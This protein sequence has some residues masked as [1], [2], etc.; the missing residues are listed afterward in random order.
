MA[1][2]DIAPD[3]TTTLIGSDKVE[4]TSV[5]DPSGDKL[6]SIHNF[7]VDKKS[8]QAKYAVL[9]FGG[10]LG[11]G[12]DY[13]PV[14]WQS[15]TYDTNKNGYVVDIDKNTLKSGPRYNVNDEPEY[16]RA[17]GETINGH[18]GMDDPDPRHA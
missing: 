8:G 17:Y 6:G 13:C 1:E 12:A 2:H 3:E 14:P 9:S 16:D 10:V 18:Y 15:L 7:M 5:F 11:M 4:G